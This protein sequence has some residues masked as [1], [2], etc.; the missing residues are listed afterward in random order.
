MCSSIE[1]GVERESAMSEGTRT[2]AHCQLNSGQTAQ[3]A[4][5]SLCLWATG[6]FGY[7]T[8]VQP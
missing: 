8:G 5:Q 1:E 2:V 7:E 6:I 3:C 4:N